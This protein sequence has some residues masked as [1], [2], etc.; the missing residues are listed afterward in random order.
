MLCIL[1]I[2]KGPISFSSLKLPFFIIF[3]DCNLDC[4]FPWPLKK[5]R[6]RQ[7]GTIFRQSILNCSGEETLRKAVVCIIKG[8]V[9]LHQ[10][11][12]FV[13]FSS[14]HQQHLLCNEHVVRDALFSALLLFI[15]R[16]AS[17]QVVDAVCEV[18]HEDPFT[19]LFVL[20]FCRNYGASELG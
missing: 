10:R 15:L 3:F 19:C 20:Y 16:D 8:K 9:G 17:L 18:S 7:W 12:P 13:K 1:K 4:S 5:D 11:E 6:W 2:I 14:P